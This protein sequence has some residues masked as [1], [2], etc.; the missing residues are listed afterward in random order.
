MENK[1]DIYY[2][3]FFEGLPKLPDDQFKAYMEEWRRKKKVF[4]EKPLLNNLTKN[5]IWQDRAKFYFLPFLVNCYKFTRQNKLPMFAIPVSPTCMFYRDRLHLRNFMD[6]VHQAFF[7]MMDVC[8][9]KGEQIMLL[10]EKHF[11]ITDPIDG[12]TQQLYNML[13]DVDLEPV[14][15]KVYLPPGQNFKPRMG[16]PSEPIQYPTAWK[17]DDLN[18]GVP[19]DGIELLRKTLWFRDDLDFLCKRYDLD[20]Q[21]VSKEIVDLTNVPEDKKELYE[22]TARTF[23]FRIFTPKYVDNDDVEVVSS[24]SDLD[25]FDDDDFEID[26][27]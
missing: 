10:V 14:V 12:G 11:Y 23:Y 3:E 19:A 4:A 5:D 21:Y 20:G 13:W 1:S 22:K 25:D 6:T 18:P 26:S 7:A 8:I 9:P 16:V 15:N 24:D 27:T 2:N 17:K